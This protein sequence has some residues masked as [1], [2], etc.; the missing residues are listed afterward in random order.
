MVKELGKLFDSAEQANRFL[1]EDLA[2][3][4]RTQAKRAKQLSLA[5]PPK[6]I[7]SVM[8]WPVRDQADNG[9]RMR[10]RNRQRQRQ[11]KHLAK[12]KNRASRSQ[13]TSNAGSFS[14][15]ARIVA[16]ALRLAP[17]LHSAPLI[18]LN[19]RETTHAPC[20]ELGHSQSTRGAP[21]VWAD[22]R[23]E[24][25][26]GLQYFRSYHSGAYG[27]NG[28]VSGYL[29]DGHNADGDRIGG[30]IIISHAGGKYSAA[31]GKLHADQ[32]ITDRS[33]AALMKNLTH[34]VPLV[35]IAGNRWPSRVQ[36]NHRY[37]V[38]GWF[39]VTHIWPECRSTGTVFRVRFE[40]LD[41]EVGWWAPSVM[42]DHILNG[43]LGQFFC[44]TCESGSPVLYS[45]A[46]CLNRDC[47]AYATGQLSL[48]AL[49]LRMASNRGISGP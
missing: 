45:P 4:S 34:D 40:T 44:H 18:E 11:R 28:F 7:A 43:Q 16:T 42:R 48:D 19:A 6:S 12:R 15:E 27:K 24:L 35:L 49:F 1:G 36:L 38:L 13:S 30:R 39:R 26:E 47:S 23:Q 41:A 5:T 25:C 37:N 21:S 10:E 14:C 20:D 29:I 22:T 9:E 8:T 31:E 33:V 2:F 17:A 3:W 32:T 46:T